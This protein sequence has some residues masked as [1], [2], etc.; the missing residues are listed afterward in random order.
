MEKKPNAE[1]L[2]YRCAADAKSQL[3]RETT[4]MLLKNATDTLSP[5]NGAAVHQGAWTQGWPDGLFNEYQLYITLVQQ[6]RAAIER[7]MSS[8]GISLRSPEALMLERE[9]TRFHNDCLDFSIRMR[10]S[11]TSSISTGF[12]SGRG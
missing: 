9:C 12:S 1:F 2:A 10:D 5:E 3:H 7:T 11:T 8:R 6:K 4:K